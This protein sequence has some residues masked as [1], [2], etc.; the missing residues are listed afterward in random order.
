MYPHFLHHAKIQPAHLPIGF[1]TVIQIQ[2]ALNLTACTAQ[3]HHRQAT[4]VVASGQHAGTE[5]DHGVIQSRAIPLLDRIQTSGDVS[6]LFEK[7]LVDF[8]PVVRVAVRK[9]MVDHVVD[10]D[11]RKP[12]RSVIVIKFQRADPSRVRLKRQDKD[13]LG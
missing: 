7:E 4:G 12:Q 3:H 8:Q 1:A 5:H 11:M 6:H 9:E 10:A 13:C 2:A